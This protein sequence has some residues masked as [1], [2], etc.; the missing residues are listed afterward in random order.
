MAPTVGCDCARSARASRAEPKGAPWPW[1]A[2]TGRWATSG[3]TARTCTSASPPSAKGRPHKLLQNLGHFGDWGHQFSLTVGLAGGMGSR[4]KPWAPQLQLLWVS[5]PRFRPP[6]VTGIVERGQGGKTS[7]SP[8][9]CERE[10]RE[11]LAEGAFG[12]PVVR[13]LHFQRKECRLNPWPGN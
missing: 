2:S 10:H 12:S 6:R 7:S 13:T 9:S 4:G 5:L 1:D 8:L 3:Q 11:G